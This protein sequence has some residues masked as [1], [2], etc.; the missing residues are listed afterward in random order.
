MNLNNS[1]FREAEDIFRRFGMDTGMRSAGVADGEWVPVANITETDKEYLIKAELPEVKKD[2][3]RVTLQDGVITLE[4]ER[5]REYDEAGESDLLLESPY[6]A[7]SR[8]FRLPRN[9]NAQAIRAES[10]NGIL[11]IHIPK[12]ES[13]RPKQIAIEVG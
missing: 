3:V 11:Q 4:G 9:I 5:M 10:R 1:L 8:S 6:G 12:T 2:D 7:F 13:A